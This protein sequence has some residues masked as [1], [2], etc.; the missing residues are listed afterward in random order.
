MRNCKDD[1]ISDSRMAAKN[2]LNLK[3]R[4]LLPATVYDLLETAR[5]N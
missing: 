5:E 2:M 3:R 1:E 4:Y